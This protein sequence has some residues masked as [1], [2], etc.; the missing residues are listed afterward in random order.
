MKRF[1]CKRI[2]PTFHPEELTHTKLITF[3]S[4]IIPS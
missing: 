4:Q 3:T 1:A 2:L